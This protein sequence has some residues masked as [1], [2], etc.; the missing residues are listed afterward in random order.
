MEKQMPSMAKVNKRVMR[1]TLGILLASMLVGCGEE[2]GV[3]EEMGRAA[4][5]NTCNS[6]G[7]CEAEL[8]E[9]CAT[10]PKDCC[11]TCEVNI[12]S[13][14]ATQKAFLPAFST[15]WANYIRDQ[16]S[17]VQP[18]PTVVA[19]TVDYQTVNTRIFANPGEYG[20][21]CAIRMSD[22][23]NKSGKLLP[24]TYAYKFAPVDYQSD[25]WLQRIKNG[26]G[27]EYLLTVHEK[28]KCGNGICE[29]GETNGT[30][31]RDCPSTSC[32]NNICD[33]GESYSCPSDCRATKYYA[34]RAAELARYLW[35]HYGPPDYE[36]TSSKDRSCFAAAK[37]ILLVLYNRAGTYGHIDLWDGSLDQCALGAVGK[38][39]RAADA[40]KNCYFNDA[41]VYYMALWSVP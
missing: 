31:A 3:E 25:A 18:D 38:A 36:I 12:Q 13:R 32:G 23:L 21:T 19:K 20:N 5:D 22:S 33:S 16:D 9:S 17:I 1:T 11:P 41:S 29:I 7:T 37:G 24:T 2:G 27:L 40:A 39:V 35:D 14:S 15:L 4:Q 26:S 28:G 8:G 6:N 10:C 34:I 30:C